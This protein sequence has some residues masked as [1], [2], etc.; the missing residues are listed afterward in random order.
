MKRYFY[1]KYTMIQYRSAVFFF[2]FYNEAESS[3]V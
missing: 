1:T 2:T 3:R